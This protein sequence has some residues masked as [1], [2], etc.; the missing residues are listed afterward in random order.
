VSVPGLALLSGTRSAFWVSDEVYQ[1]LADGSPLDAHALDLVGAEIQRLQGLGFWPRD[2]LTWELSERHMALSL[3]LAHECNL[4]CPYCNVQQGTYGEPE[5][6]MS[7]ATARAAL[8]YLGTLSGDRSPRLVFYGGEPL[9]NWDVLTK[10]VAHAGGVLPSCAFEIITNGTLL[11]AERAAFLTAHQVFTV[12]SL[13]GPRDV[14]DRNRP[15]KTGG[16]SYGRTRRGLECLKQA[17][18]GFHIRGTWVPGTADYERVYNH[19]VELAG[20]PSK[21]TVALEFEQ[22]GSQGVATWNQR[23]Y[24]QYFA[25][26]QE[27][28]SLPPGLAP[29]LDSVLRADLA[30]VARC[31]AGHAGFSVTPDGTLYPCQVS[32]SLKQFPLGNVWDGIDE[33]GRQNLEVFLHPAS[34]ECDAC[35]ARDFCAGPCPYSTPVPHDW[36][37]CRT[38]RLQVRQA[39]E[40]AAE[41]PLEKMAG[42]GP[43]DEETARDS[44]RAAALR[45]LLWKQNTHIRPL[46]LYPQ[47]DR[48]A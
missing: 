48:P 4:A 8:D 20:D 11:D 44:E 26:R 13:D 7:E 14:H 15:M 34:P 28:A 40:W 33:Q 39:L 37:Y 3:H 17:G 9:L 38:I 10:V 18:A 35:W 16:G 1:A 6:R 24:D 5:S 42:F 32:A 19:L 21:V 46:A 45:D 47:P 27:Q 25:A 29:F 41:T 36:P 12:L 43:Q 2:P 22:S 23:L 31:E 30:P